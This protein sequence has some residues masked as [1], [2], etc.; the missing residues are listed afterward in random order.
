MVAEVESPEI[1][2][3]LWRA[4][5]GSGSGLGTGGM[6]TK[7]QAADLAR[8]AGITA[9][10]ALGAEP[11][12][13]ERLVAG[14]RLGTR[15][16]PTATRL[17]SRKRYILSG[18]TGGQVTVDDGAARALARGSSLLPVGVTAV[19]GEFERGDTVRRPH[20]VAVGLSQGRR[21]A[22]RIASA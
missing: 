20:Q 18:G 17:E 21:G 1:P 15:F 19:A 14:E 8:R 11:R 7:L 10:I 22:L 6:V 16:L 3:S 13:L 5:G 4:A 9:V 12:I 2:D